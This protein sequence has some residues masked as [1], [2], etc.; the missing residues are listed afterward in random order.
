[1]K[2][3]KK[4]GIFCLVVSVSVAML[5]GC[6][7][8]KD[9]LKETSKLDDDYVM[10]ISY[11]TGL[12]AA[13]LQMAVEKGFLK[14]EGIKYELL[15]SDK[16]S[17]DLM[18]SGKSDTFLEML[19]AMI[20]QIDNGLDA[21]IAMGVHTGC[22]KLLTKPD[23]PINGVKDLK[24]KKIGVPGLASSQTIIAQRALLAAGIGVSPENMEVEFVVYNQ[25][26]LPLA[27][28]N[29]QVDAIGM[30]D[31]SASLVVNSGDAKI[32]LDN[33]VDK[34]Y[35]N[36]YCCVLVL[37]PDFVKEHPEIAKKYVRAMKKAGEYVQNNPEEVAQIQID[38]KLVAL[39]DP[40]F[41]SGILKTYNFVPSVV[42]GKESLIKNFN[43]LQ[44]I[45]FIS[46]DLDVDK[47]V[48]KI[49]VEFDGIDD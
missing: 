11:G 31:P 29:G 26:E 10:Q 28:K 12:C 18:M 22:L 20:Q 41:N 35:K 48:D 39:G 37:R 38:K 15:K 34:E 32:I 5:V 44:K 45:K 30:S 17:V 8:S 42:K 19:P 46:Q 6:S 4:L 13:P 33:G 16:S 40:T 21:R 7:K 3:L 9:K 49:Y 43:D 36:E 24:G 47:V 27:L 23:S 25:P 1:M 2:K 14:E